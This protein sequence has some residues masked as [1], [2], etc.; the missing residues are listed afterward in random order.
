[1]NLKDK[2][3][4]KFETAEI[5]ALPDAP[6]FALQGVSAKDAELLKKSFN[7]ITIRDLADLKYAKW[8]RELSESPH[9]LPLFK[10]RLDKKYENYTAEKIL[11]SPLDALQGLS[12][13]DAERLYKAFKIKTVGGLA[14]L[15]YIEWA[16]E[17]VALAQ[18][19]ETLEP[20]PAARDSRSGALLFIGLVAAAI[21]IAF[22]FAPVCNR[23][24][25]DYEV[26]KN[27]PPEK[28]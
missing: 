21:I 6:I 14:G 3:T 13:P 17:I 22:V 28:I 5:S 9:D 1:M 8:A 2:L 15:K 16:R 23:Y 7:I 10:D 26:R 25:N 20:G 24:L 19:R 11:K 4:K 18:P 12:K 27:N